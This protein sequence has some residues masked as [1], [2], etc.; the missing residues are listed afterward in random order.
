[1]LYSLLMSAK[2]EQMIHPP[3]PPHIFSHNIYIV[4]STLIPL[5]LA[6]LWNALGLNVRGGL[7]C[8]LAHA[9]ITKILH[10]LLPSKT[11]FLFHQYF[12]SHFSTTFSATSLPCL[13][14]I[15][16]AICT[17]QVKLP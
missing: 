11:Y 12:L 16:Q 14:Q 7:L 9:S 6:N 8:I 10:V 15:R 13:C 17:E 2:C 3:P 5:L 4:A 1:M